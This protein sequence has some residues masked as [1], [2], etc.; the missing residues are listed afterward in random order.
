M[1]VMS[2][3][4]T[5]ISQDWCGSAVAA[6]VFD[7][8]WHMWWLNFKRVDAIAVSFYFLHNLVISPFRTGIFGTHKHMQYEY[9]T[10]TKA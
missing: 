10:H 3:V 5:T 8:M 9:R 1:L 4:T 7:V 2:R 6:G